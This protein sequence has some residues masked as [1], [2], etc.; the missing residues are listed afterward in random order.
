MIKY[1]IEPYIVGNSYSTYDGFK[2]GGIGYACYVKTGN[3]FTIHFKSYQDIHSSPT[4]EE[5]K[6]YLTK[7]LKGYIDDPQL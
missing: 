5:A 3:R 4:Y 7:K 1:K 2:D 6:I